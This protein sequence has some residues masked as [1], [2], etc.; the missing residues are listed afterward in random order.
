MATKQLYFSE[1]QG[2]YKRLARLVA[3][4]SELDGERVSE[5]EVVR[6]AMKAY[7]KELEKKM[8]RRRR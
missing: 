2:D 3:T 4:A 8:K 1:K 6:R 7:E 5:S